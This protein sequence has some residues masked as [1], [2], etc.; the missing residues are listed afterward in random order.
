MTVKEL[1]EILK[2]VDEDTKV[3]VINADNGVTYTTDFEV[4]QGMNT[5]NIYFEQTFPKQTFA[6]VL[7]G[8]LVNFFTI[9]L[10]LDFFLK[11]VYNLIVRLRQEIKKLKFFL[12]KLKKF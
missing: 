8:R 4:I 9:K 6:F 10:N 2:N 12:K 5:K 3:Y 7:T 11:F 1:M